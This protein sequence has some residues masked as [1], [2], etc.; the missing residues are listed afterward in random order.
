MAVDGKV[1]SW[2]LVPGKGTGLDRLIW[3]RNRICDVYEKAKPDLIVME[4]FSFGSNMSFVREIAG[5]AFMIRAEIHR[6]KIPT[7]LV[8][9]SS[10]KKFIVG[11][12]GSSKQKV[13]KDLILK[14]MLRRFGHDLTDNNVADAV[15]LAYIGMAM[16]EEWAPTIEPQRDVLK[17]LRDKNPNLRSIAA[18]NPPVDSQPALEDSWLTE[19]PSR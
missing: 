19:E 18:A 1:E 8:S 17:Q 10:L 6:A 7:L 16:V 12:A 13:G 2:G 15:G 9:P 14:E 4:D 11:T 5:M 3:N